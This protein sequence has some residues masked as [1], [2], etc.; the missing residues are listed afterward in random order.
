MSRDEAGAHLDAA[1]PP[2]APNSDPLLLRVQDAL[3]DAFRQGQ[4]RLPAVARATGMSTRTLRRRLSERGTSF[5]GLV[6]A[7][8]RELACE[9]LR[10]TEDSVATIAELT[11]FASVSAF[12]RAFQRW[13]GLPAS[14]YRERARAES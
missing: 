4:A 7:L 14:A 3:A 1:L 11:G 5:Q 9:R 8:R 2:T 12:Q 6:D 10:L 13:T